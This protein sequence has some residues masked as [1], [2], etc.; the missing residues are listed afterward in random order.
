MHISA[1]YYPWIRKSKPTENDPTSNKWARTVP[2]RYAHNPATFLTILVS[3][4]SLTFS[5]RPFYVHCGTPGTADRD[6]GTRKYGHF[7]VCW[8]VVQ[9]EF[10]VVTNIYNFILSPI[11]SNSRQYPSNPRYFEPLEKS[12]SFQTLHETYKFA[13]R[14][15]QYLFIPQRYLWEGQYKSV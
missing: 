6:W 7:S 11:P 5:R 4:V 15:N 3:G 10:L 12:V 9:Q 8:A 1:R 14:Y 2:G 13:Y